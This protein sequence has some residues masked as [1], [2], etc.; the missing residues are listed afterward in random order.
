[1]TSSASEPLRQALNEMD[2]LRRRCLWMTRFLIVLWIVCW[3]AT[4]VA[5]L[6]GRNLGLGVV[7][8]L[9][10]VMVGV[11]SVGVNGG[12]LAYANTTKILIALEKLTS[13]QAQA[14][15]DERS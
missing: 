11:F 9:N 3:C 14:M 13:A 15:R 2:K 8:A 10:T 1:M 4:D 6:W 12:G 7:F 5:I